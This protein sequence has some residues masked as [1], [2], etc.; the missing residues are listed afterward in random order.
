MNNFL[1]QSKPAL[2]GGELGLEWAN[3]HDAV[4]GGRQEEDVLLLKAELGGDDDD[5]GD[6][7]KEDDEGLVRS[8]VDDAKSQ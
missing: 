2:S 7:Y 5:N 8:K 6:V 1:E 4:V 3:A